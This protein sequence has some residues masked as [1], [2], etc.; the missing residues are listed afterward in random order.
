MMFVA[1]ALVLV[2][3]L[4]VA[5]VR[6]LPGRG[7]KPLRALAIAYTDF[8]RGTPIIIVAFIVGFGLP[9]LQLG[10][11]SNRSFTVYGIIALTLVVHRVRQRGVRAGIEAVHPSQR[12]A[13]RS[14]GL[15]YAQTM[16]Y[17]VVP[18]S[19]PA[20]DPAAAERLR[21]A[22]EGHRD[23]VGDRRR[24]G[25]VAR[26]AILDPE[27][28]LRLVRRRCGLLHPDH[29]SRSRASP[30]ISSPS[31]RSASA[32]RR[33]D[34]RAR[35]GA[36][37]SSDSRRLEVV[38]RPHGARQI[39]LTV[40]STKSSA[41]SAP[42]DPASR[43]CCAASTCSSGSRR[44]RS[45]STAERSPTA[46]RRQCAAP[47]GRHRLPGVQPLS[48]HDGAPERDA[49][50]AEGRAAPRAAR[51]A[52]RRACSTH[53]ARG[54]DTCIPI[55]SAAAS[56]SA[57]RSSARSRRAGGL[58]LDEITSA[59]DPQLVSRCSELVR[60]WP[61]RMTMIIATHEMGF[62]REVADKCAS[63]T[64]ADPRGGDAGADLHRST[65]APHARVPRAR[66]R[67]GEAGMST[68]SRT[69]RHAAASA[70]RSPDHSGSAAA[71]AHRSQ[72]P[73]SSRS[74]SSSRR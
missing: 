9:G 5:I 64:P 61:S 27:R 11:I 13:A 66:P 73:R 3:A 56:S 44:A 12:S 72:S 4:I 25:S 40:P 57:S 18:A 70:T 65:R 8:F 39:D 1:E 68:S 20:R 47:Q 50:A 34:A 16:R 26:A 15:S 48:A 42:R 63:S 29:D 41:S 32:P 71:A 58:L 6:G 23:R 19:D 55:V 59:L 21:R 14:L 7:A 10:F 37:R 69:P 33:S 62:A 54:K 17:I 2:F 52:S 53:R 67:C 45:S 36:S 24:R 46:S 28:R 38:R 35:T 74:R 49:R 31:A 51:S 30:I 22:A 60:D 43:R